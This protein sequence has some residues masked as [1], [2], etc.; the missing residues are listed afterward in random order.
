MINKFIQEDVLCILYQIFYDSKLPYFHVKTSSFLTIFKKQYPLKYQKNE[1]YIINI[2]L[3]LYNIRELKI[4]PK[5]KCNKKNVKL[6]KFSKR[7]VKERIN[8]RRLRIQKY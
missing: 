3:L 1:M 2:P 6:L 4:C 5:I 8:E 7:K